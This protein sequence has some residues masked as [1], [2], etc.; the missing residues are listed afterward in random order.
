MLVD[1]R[2]AEIER[3]PVEHVA[4]IA[5]RERQRDALVGAQVVEIHGHRERGHLALGH[6]AVGHAAH[7]RG[8]AVA[9]EPLPVALSANEFLR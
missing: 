4:R 5:L 6:A 2:P 3:A 7:E 9:I 8:H 1:H